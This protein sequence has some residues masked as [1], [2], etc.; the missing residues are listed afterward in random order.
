MFSLG[1]WTVRCRTEVRASFV[2]I[3]SVYGSVISNIYGFG[4]DLVV[5]VVLELE[6]KKSL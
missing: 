1:S 6:R 3:S 5:L 4:V 2:R